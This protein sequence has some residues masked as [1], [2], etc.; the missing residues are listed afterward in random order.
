MKE[1]KFIE[2]NQKKW[3]EF[4]KALSSSQ[5]KPEELSKL[6]L[7]VT[8]DLGYAQTFYN[9]RTIRVYLNQLAQKVFIGV[10]K[11]GGQSWKKILDYVLVSIPIDIY[12]SRKSLLIALIS[13][14]IYA[15]IGVITTY[16]NPDFPRVVMGDGY[17]DMTIENISNGRPLAVYE[18]QSQLDMFIHITTNNLRV[19]LLTFFAGFFGIIGTQMLL[20]SNGVM[21]GSF[22]YFF[23]TKGLLVTSFLG[24]WIH[25][26]FE[27]SAIVLAGGAGIVAGGG[28]LFPK[29]YSRIQ[30]LRI[31]ALR[32]MKIMMSLIP[33]IIIAGFLESYVTRHYQIL[34]EWSKWCIIF[35][36]FAIIVFYYVIYPFFI[37]RK[38]PERAREDDLV[39]L[40]T[41]DE[42]VLYK[43]R[44]EGAIIRDAFHSYFTYSAKFLK[45]IFTIYLPL[46]IVIAFV[47]GQIHMDK[48]LTQHWFDWY[49]HAQIIFG[50]GLYNFTDLLFGFSWS[51]IVVGI[52]ATVFWSIKTRG[53]EF[54]YS[55]L[56]RYYKERFITLYI[57]FAIYYWTFFFTPIYLKFILL[58]LLPFVTSNIAVAAFDEGKGKIK[59]AFLYGRKTFVPSLLNLLFFST[60]IAVLVQPI[61]FI[62]SIQENWSSEPTMRDLLD[63][64]TDFINRVAIFFTDDYMYYSNSF[65]QIIY[66]I[67]ILLTLP[68]FALLTAFTYF[69]YAEKEELIGLREEFKLFGKRKRN[70]E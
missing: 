3:S 66:I 4:E 62:F 59:K 16:V 26:A 21:L 54:S 10:H 45:P 22:Q 58:F 12:K 35:F 51:L 56:F 30:A 70:Q 27:I 64:C 33:F 65:R 23:H 50:F 17:V 24:I 19:A 47:Q 8:E 68:L 53:E 15:A 37:V 61:A 69:S 14:L 48:M 67:F 42:V 40:Q 29:S 46:A 1:T 28:L 20:F 39:D 25:G 6:Y 5:K 49:V 11:Q 41:K 55:S 34:P 13:F 52:F 60:L 7:D 43:I 32:G 18:S 44:K 57:A 38:Y 31:S 36:S 9:R 2:Q 63:V